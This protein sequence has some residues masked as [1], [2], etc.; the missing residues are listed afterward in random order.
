MLALSAI[1]SF[2][3]GPLQQHPCDSEQVQS[4]EGSQFVASGPVAL[5]SPVALRRSPCKVEHSCRVGCVCTSVVSGL[6]GPGPLAQS[7]HDSP[8]CKA[9]RLVSQCFGAQSSVGGGRNA[10][11]A[12]NQEAPVNG[13][14]KNDAVA[15]DAPVSGS[16]ASEANDSFRLTASVSDGSAKEASKEA[17]YVHG[18]QVNEASGVASSVCGCWY[19]VAGS[20]G[21]LVSGGYVNK[22]IAQGASVDDGVRNKADGVQSSVSGC[23]PV[24]LALDSAVGCARAHNCRIV[25]CA[26]K[27]EADRTGS[28]GT[29]P[30]D[31]A[32]RQGG[33]S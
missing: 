30:S 8:G 21:A 15:K 9:P 13:G 28:C 26:A 33:I 23:H 22:T 7:E 12:T 3:H 24:W 17:A 10:T 5:R 25:A 4:S 14:I 2:A 16:T 31:D 20:T 32:T 1:S 29:Y 18:S 11:M 27:E 19:N 6:A